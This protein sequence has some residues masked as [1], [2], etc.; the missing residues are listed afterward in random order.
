[1]IVYVTNNKEPWTLN[2]EQTLRCAQLSA[3]SLQSFVVLIWGVTIPHWD[4]MYDIF[5]MQNIIRR[6]FEK[7]WE[8][9]QQ[10][11]P[12]MFNEWTKKTCF[13]EERKSYRFRPMQRWVNDDTI[14]IFVRI[15]PLSYS[16]FQ[17]YSSNKCYSYKE[18]K[19]SCF[20]LEETAAILVGHKI[21]IKVDDNTHWSW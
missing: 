7:H 21:Q 12:K 6:Y 4:T 17:L 18:L 9:E 20:L 19:M 16:D 8:S 5:L 13:T 14:F 10:W 11:T 1:M 3:H 15:I 2:L